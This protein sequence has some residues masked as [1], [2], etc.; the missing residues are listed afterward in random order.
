MSWTSPRWRWG[1]RSRS[2]QTRWRAKTFTGTVTKV[3]VAGTTS[4]GITSYPVT[5]RIDGA[6]E[7]LPG[8]NVDA[9]IVLGRPPILLAIPSSA[10]AGA[11]EHLSGSRHP[12]LSQCGKRCGAGG[13]EGATP[14]FKWR[15]VSAMTAMSRSSAACRG[16][17]TAAYVARSTESGSMMM[18]G[19]PGA[20]GGD[21]PAGMPSG[22][23]GAPGGGMPSGGPGGGFRD[24][25]ADRIS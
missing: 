20:M 15:P 6:D 16:G 14:M 8:M 1:R 7:L 13:P 10:V 21:M 12:G 24:E 18:G 25:R 19:M 23:G 3:S 11:A 22:M 17:D 5:V 9:E 2:P 4:G